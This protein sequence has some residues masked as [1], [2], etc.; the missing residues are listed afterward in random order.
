M[1]GRKPKLGT[2]AMK[3]VVISARVKRNEKLYSKA[4]QEQKYF[5]KYK[6]ISFS[7]FGKIEPLTILGV[8]PLSVNPDIKGI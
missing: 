6:G 4:K 5:G 7:P 2:N 3:T 1:V 8:K